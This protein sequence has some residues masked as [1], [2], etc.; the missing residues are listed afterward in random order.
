MSWYD[1][2]PYKTPWDQTWHMLWG[3]VPW[4]T[5]ATLFGYDKYAVIT[6]TWGAIVA[7]SMLAF[8]VREILQWPSK[9]WWDPY[10][11]CLVFGTA[12]G[13]GIWLGLR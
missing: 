13:V 3:G 5:Y 2:E 9:R 11:D 7:L 6:W 8:I 10:L 4:W 1:E 12:S